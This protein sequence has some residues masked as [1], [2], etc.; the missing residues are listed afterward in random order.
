MLTQVDRYVVY[1]F[2]RVLGV[3][4]ISFIAIYVVVDLVDHLD[5]FLERDLGVFTILRYYLH[6]TP[7][8]VS[9]TLPLG[10]LLSTL[11]VIG[12]MGAQNELVAIK[13]AGISIYRIAWP[14]LRLGVIV[15]ALA[16]LLGELVVPQSNDIRRGIL[17]VR[18]V[19]TS[20][21]HARHVTRQDRSG[22]VLYAAYYNFAAKR[23]SNVTIVQ[24]ADRTSQRRIDA[25]EMEWDEQGW[26]L[27]NATD[28]VLRGGGQILTEHV[29]MRLPMLS[30]LPEDLARARKDPEQMSYLELRDFMDRLRS[31][32][33]DDARWLVDLHLKVAFPLA[34]F[35]MVWLGF[36][37]AAR[38][39][40]G[41]KAVYIGWTLLI[42]FM[43][44]VTIRA[45][46]AMGRAGSI[47]PAIGAWTADGLFLIIGA[48]SYRWTRK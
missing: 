41:G 34:N 43:F 14:L 45:G 28:R 30:L 18:R 1:R 44:F 21:T 25:A 5:D 40:R 48:I 27:L 46:Q 9:L 20:R 39:W 31:A 3:T 2:C 17:D 7:Y 35:M 38:T 37:I 19:S 8:I 22:F 32:G 36:P 4:V 12:D 13:A 26:L 29:S 42:G 23:A 47:P 16:L 6:Y 11:F 10:M 33:G 24:I 15:A